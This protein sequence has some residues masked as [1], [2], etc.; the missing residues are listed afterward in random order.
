MRTPKE[1]KIQKKAPLI[2]QLLPANNKN[3][4]R[5]R[6]PL[7]LGALTFTFMNFAYTSAMPSPFTPFPLASRGG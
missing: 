6:I 4:N 7:I 5:A 2:P 1:T 3:A